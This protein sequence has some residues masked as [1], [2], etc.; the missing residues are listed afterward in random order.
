M[1]ED[2][3]T[4]CGKKIDDMNSKYHTILLAVKK[5]VYVHA[6]NGMCSFR[7]Y[8]K[9]SEHAVCIFVCMI[10]FLRNFYAETEIKLTS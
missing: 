9:N 2:G 8:G 6:A 4:Q 1:N 5:C 7:A 10:F 3:T